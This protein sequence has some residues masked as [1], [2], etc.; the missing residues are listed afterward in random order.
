MVWNLKKMKSSKLEGH[1]N[2]ISEVKFIE[3][4][5]GTQLLTASCDKTMIAWEYDPKSKEY[6][7]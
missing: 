4:E 7:K 2:W 3:R 5:Q 6:I 1:I